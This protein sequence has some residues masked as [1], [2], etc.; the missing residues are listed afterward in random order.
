M[1]PDLD[2]LHELFELANNIGG[3]LSLVQASG[4]NVSIKAD[5]TLVVKASGYRLED[6]GRIEG[7]VALRIEQGR[8]LLAKEPAA[9]ID[10]AIV[11][12]GREGSRPSIETSFHLHVPG[13]VVAHV[14][15]IGSIAVGLRRDCAELLSSISLGADVLLVKYAQPGTDLTAG[16]L[17]AGVRSLTGSTVIVL[18]NHGLLVWAE[19]ASECVRL[20]S[21]FESKVRTLMQPDRAI[22]DAIEK[23]LQGV[24][25]NRF[26]MDFILDPLWLDFLSSHIL[27]P[28]QAV[29]LESVNISQSINEIGEERS[30]NPVTNTY[31]FVPSLTNSQR[32]VL[33]MLIALGGFLR[34]VDCTQT[35]DVGQ[36]LRLT[37]LES[38]QY[39]KSIAK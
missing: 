23:F 7:Y 8:T 18:R 20:I 30:I 4:G 17:E 38:E 39:R 21:E 34:T 12:C 22:R 29:F 2:T 9:P 14:H 3:D 31:N 19:S 24:T 15:S 25:K 27:V 11:W 37:K 36:A 26:K 1:N 5:D 28:D 6:C 32:E 16:L 13:R 10:E 35:I 33:A